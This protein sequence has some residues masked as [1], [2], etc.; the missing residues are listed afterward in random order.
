MNTVSLEVAK[1]LKEAGWEKKSLFCSQKNK[2][3]LFLLKTVQAHNDYFPVKRKDI[4]VR[5]QLHEILEELPD[6]ITH[7]TANMFLKVEKFEDDYIVGYYE[8]SE[9]PWGE[10]KNENPHDAASLLW[11]WCVENGYIS[12][13]NMDT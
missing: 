11:I 3:H 2:E 6:K 5:P 7:G 12:L 9:Y 10:Q 8:F 4:L 1:K 13:P